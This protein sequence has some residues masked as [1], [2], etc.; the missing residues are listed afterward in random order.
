M[1]HK[2]H[3]AQAEADVVAVVERHAVDATKQKK[4]E[5]K[6]AGVDAVKPILEAAEICKLKV[7]EL[8]WQIK[9]HR[10]HGVG[11]MPMQ[12]HLNIQDK[13]IVAL[14]EAAEVQQEGGDEQ[15]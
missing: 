7:K 12:K 4:C 3:Q 10:S 6:Q 5:E 1:E 15:K 14:L 9:W 13:K 8:D 11:T 2:P